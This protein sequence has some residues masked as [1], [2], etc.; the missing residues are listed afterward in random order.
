MKLIKFLFNVWGKYKNRSKFVSK[1]LS[2]STINQVVSSGA[3]FALGIYLVRVLAPIDFG[4]YGIGFAI[5]LLYAGVGNALFLTQMVVHVPEKSQDDKL[6]Y[7]ARMLVALIIFCAFT[8]II[9]GLLLVLS[10]SWS[11]SI[12]KYIG[13]AVSIVAASI[14]Y[15]VKDFFVRHAYTVRRESWALWINITVAVT[16]A[17]LLLM[18]FRFSSGFK[19]ESAL[20]IYAASNMMGGV[21]GFALVR[22]PIF[23]VRIG[24]LGDDLR[25]A[26]VGGRWA[27]VGVAITWMQ[28]QA[29]MYVTAVFVGPVGVAYANSARLLITPAIFI[30]PALSQVMMP[31]LASFRISNPEKMLQISKIFTLGAV[32]FSVGY[33]VILLSLVDMISPVLLGEQYGRISPV[34]AAWC[35]VVIFQFSRAG[36]S[37]V[38]QVIKEFKILTLINFVSVV[39]AITVA[40]LLMQLIGISGA[41]LGTAI[42]ELVLSVLLHKIIIKYKQRTS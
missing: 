18:Q 10:G 36:S 15:V 7:A 19:P 35:L 39:I 17:V 30:M 5:S 9:F 14:S 12:N 34:V 16:L 2:I 24:Q 29:Y 40:V 32:I 41:I 13:L 25:E 8:V 1:A 23:A 21:I 31:R 20:W 28:T 42:G 37:I 3:N 4:L 27:L 38:L 6:P 33:S 22:L 26:W 11:E